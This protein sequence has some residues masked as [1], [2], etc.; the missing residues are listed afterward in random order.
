MNEQIIDALREAGA[1]F[2][3]SLKLRFSAEH[4]II[5]DTQLVGA[6]AE[7]RVF[8]GYLSPSAVD[9]SFWENRDAGEY[10]AFRHTDEKNAYEQELRDC[11]RLTFS[12]NE[13][14]LTL[15]KDVE[16][17]VKDGEMTMEAAEANAKSVLQEYQRYCDGE[18]Y[19][20]VVE[21]VDIDLDTGAITYKDIDNCWDYIGFDYATETLKEEFDQRHEVVAA[22]SMSM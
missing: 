7:G 12:D 1:Q 13:G 19:G 8:V 17:S 9:G 10:K 14:V 20:W 4:P 15:P 11:G 5:D 22:P 3:D 21:T 16:K 18:V 6:T 2:A